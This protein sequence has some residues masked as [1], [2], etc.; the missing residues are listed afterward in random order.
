MSSN[1]S[2]RDIAYAALTDVASEPL[3]PVD[4]GNLAYIIMFYEGVGCMYTNRF[5]NLI[6]Y[7][8]DSFQYSGG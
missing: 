7:S 6:F 3:Q 4:T 2:K 1:N 5:I 8:L